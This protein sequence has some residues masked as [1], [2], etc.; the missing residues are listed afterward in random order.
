MKYTEKLFLNLIN[1]I[2]KDQNN[3]SLIIVVTLF[4][5]TN[6]VYFF[7]V[8]KIDELLIKLKDISKHNVISKLFILD[9]L[10]INTIKQIHDITGATIYLNEYNLEKIPTYVKFYNNKFQYIKNLEQIDNIEE[11]IYQELDFKN[12]INEEIS[13]GKKL[14]VI[15]KQLINEKILIEDNNKEV[16]LLSNIGQLIFKKEIDTSRQVIISDEEIS[17]NHSYCNKQIFNETL[18]TLHNKIAKYIYDLLPQI[19]SKEERV[20]SSLNKPLSYELLVKL[21]DYVLLNHDF[22]EGAP[23]DIIK[24]PIGIR[25]TFI[26]RNNLILKNFFKKHLDTPSFKDIINMFL[27]NNNISIEKYNKSSNTIINILFDRAISKYDIALDSIEYGIIDI[28]NRND[29]FKRSLIDEV[30][31]ISPRTSNKYLNR[32][33]SLGIISKKGIG[34]DIKYYKV[35]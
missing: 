25:I 5:Y 13:K 23:I 30:F 10:N 6:D 28:A 14:Q 34:K 2:N 7:E 27:L 22:I 29:Y 31:K 11:I 16:L 3:E 12:F 21:I 15:I 35:K 4:K 1:L 24:T 32:L 33:K 9:K 8:K 19:K 18:Y 17:N 26:E 20:R